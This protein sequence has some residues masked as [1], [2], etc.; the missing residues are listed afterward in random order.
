[1]ARMGNNHVMWD[2]R[3][4]FGKQIVFKKRKTTRYVAAPP[5]VNE[6]REAS[7]GEKGNQNVFGH[8]SKRASKLIKDPALKSIYAACATGGQ[9]AYN[10]ATRDARIPPTILGILTHGYTGQP[11]SVILVQA[12]D[13]LKVKQVKVCV[14]DS[15]KQVIEEGDAV[16]NGDRLNWMYTTTVSHDNASDCSIEVK[17][18]DLAGNETIRMARVGD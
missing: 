5:N 2:V 16:D 7:E 6:N 10:V 17:A 11:G 13:N 15:S 3:G 1:M 8:A 14:Y 18:Y 12:T 9:S 4:M